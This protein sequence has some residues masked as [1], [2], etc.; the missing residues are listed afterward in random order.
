MC[1]LFVYFLGVFCLFFEI[2]VFIV[3][4]LYAVYMLCML[5]VFRM[6]IS[7]CCIESCRLS[8]T[9]LEICFVL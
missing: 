1:F 5:P 8:C 6:E 9:C 3:S 4:V 2:V 7:V